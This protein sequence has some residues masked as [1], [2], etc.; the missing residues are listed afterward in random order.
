MAWHREKE[1]VYVE[2]EG[3]YIGSITEKAV[4][5]HFDGDVWWVPKSV[6]RDHACIERWQQDVILEIE[7]WFARKAEII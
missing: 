3:C 6:I 5:V 4:Q 1:K 7:E 2:I